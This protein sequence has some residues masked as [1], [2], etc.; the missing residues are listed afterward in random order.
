MKTKQNTHIHNNNNKKKEKQKMKIFIHLSSTEFTHKAV[1]SIFDERLYWPTA[2]YEGTIELH[3]YIVTSGNI[4][5]EN[6]GDRRLSI[7]NSREI[8]WLSSASAN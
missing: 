7:A 3:A 4:Y 6:A 5:K 2:Q 8:C 1:L